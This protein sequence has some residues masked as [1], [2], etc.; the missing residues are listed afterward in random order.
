L[1]II[2]PHGDYIGLYRCKNLFPSVD[3]K[4]YYPH[5]EVRSESKDLV[6]YLVSQMTQGLTD[7]QR[8]RYDEALE[9]V[10]IREKESKK[11]RDFISRLVAE[12]DE[13]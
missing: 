11:L 7:A 2:D 4:L 3:I 5:L 1:L 12:L 10:A 8:E 9:K 13:I 6:G